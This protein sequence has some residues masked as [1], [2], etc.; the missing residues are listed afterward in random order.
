MTHYAKVVSGTVTK[1]IVADPAYFDSFVDSSPG[2]WIQ[3]SYNTR[4]GVHSNG[5]SPLRMNYAG[6]GHTYDK[7][8]DAFIAPQLYPSWVLVEATCLWEAPTPYP[9]DGED[10]VWNESTTS[11]EGI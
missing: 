3:T 5:E 6:I 10:Y 2:K 8:R 4:G 1:V 11:W 7:G 9:S